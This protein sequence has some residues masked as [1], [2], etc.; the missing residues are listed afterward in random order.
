MKIK[1][2]ALFL[3]TAKE[4]SLNI[5]KNM[6]A[7]LKSAGIAYYEIDG[8]SSAATIREGTDII[9]CIGGDGTLLKAARMAA[10]RGIRLMGVNGGSLGFLSAAEA[11]GD[12]RALLSALKNG[13]FTE[14]PRLMLDVRVMRGGKK[15]FAHKALNECVIKTGEA[16]AI[17]L[18]LSYN[19]NA[20][21]GYFGDG[22][23]ISTPTGSTAYNLAADGPIVHPAIDAFILTAICPHMLTHR[24]LVLPADK[25]LKAE[26]SPRKQG[27]RAVL[28]VDGQEHFPVDYGDE[29]IISKS[30]RRARILYPRNYNFFDV[31]TAKLKWG[32]R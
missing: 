28:N 24:P 6:A 13:D 25:V 31:L 9:F 22:I 3:N 30:A 20:L 18:N 15:V 11:D 2:A 21:K 27:L 16:R 14:S 17:S 19:S 32:S 7:R 10:R 12:F 29:V 1:T 23:I 8:N 5:R 4:Q 26:L